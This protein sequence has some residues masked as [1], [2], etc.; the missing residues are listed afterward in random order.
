VLQPLQGD[1]LN[2][3]VYDPSGNQLHKPVRALWHGM[4][5]ARTFQVVHT[6]ARQITLE[7]LSK[8]DKS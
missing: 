1:R 3:S 2:V 4:T 6:C 8:G 7:L 5:R